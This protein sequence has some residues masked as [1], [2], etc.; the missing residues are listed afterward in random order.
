MFQLTECMWVLISLPT[1]PFCRWIYNSWTL[2]CTASL[3]PTFTFPTL[4]SIKS[5]CLV[6]GVPAC[7]QLTQ[8]HFKTNSIWQHTH[9]HTVLNNDLWAMRALWLW[10]CS[11]HLQPLWQTVPVSKHRQTLTES[12]RS[13]RN[14]VTHT[15][16]ERTETSQRWSTWMLLVSWSINLLINHSITQLHVIHRWTVTINT[17]SDHA[18]EIASNPCQKTNNPVQLYCKAAILHRSQFWTI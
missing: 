17:T 10:D 5:D 15:R 11:D 3:T 16:A 13:T 8:C 9:T 18:E 12:C 2:W 14:T 4:T 6:A 7:G 1:A